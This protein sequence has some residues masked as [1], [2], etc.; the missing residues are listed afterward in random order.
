MAKENADL[1]ADLPKVEALIDRALALDEAFDY[2]AI[3][4][5]LIAYD[6]NRISG[7]GDPE[8]RARKHF[9][10]ALELSRRQQA[11]PYVT[12]AESVSLPNQDKDEFLRS[13]EQALA[14]NTDARPEWRLAN[15]IMQRKARWLLQRTGKLFID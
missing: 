3:H 6:M 4:S 11:G 14:I 5:F 9:A 15:T 13:L 1:I 8:E 7:T 2:G 10:R 12:L